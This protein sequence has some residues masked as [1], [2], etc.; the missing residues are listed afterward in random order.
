MIIFDGPAILHVH[1]SAR[2]SVRVSYMKQNSLRCSTTLWCTGLYAQTREFNPLSGHPQTIFVCRIQWETC[3]WMKET[4]PISITL[5]VSTPRHT[6]LN[7]YLGK[8]LEQVANMFIQFL[9]SINIKIHGFKHI[10]LI[11]LEHL[12]CCWL[13]PVKEQC[14][15]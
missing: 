4:D 6:R 1:L 11:I 3:D 2:P 5:K 8:H 14:E 10:Y 13:S 9:Y 7:T 12:K 15:F